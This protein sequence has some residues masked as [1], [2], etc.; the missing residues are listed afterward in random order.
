MQEL[1]ALANLK[2]SQE[3]PLPSD[4]QYSTTP[5]ETHMDF[6]WES[7]GNN[8]GVVALDADFIR[9]KQLPKTYDFPWDSSK[10]VYILASFHYLHCLVGA[11]EIKRDYQGS[12]YT[13]L[14]NAL[15]FHYGG[16]S[17]AQA[18]CSLL[19]SCPLP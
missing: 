16:S 3:I 1:K 13:V 4:T 2:Y 7:L 14:E 5:N 8:A 12:L 15:H 17:G 18:N 10:G 9:E 6:L 19:P 11:D